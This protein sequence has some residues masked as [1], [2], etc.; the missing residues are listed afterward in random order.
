MASSL[1]T[2]RE[3]VASLS[4]NEAAMTLDYLRRLRSRRAE[5][6]F[7]ELLAGDPAIRMPGAP[8]ER[9][10]EVQPVNG[11][12]IPASEMLVQDRG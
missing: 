3:T 5:T 12:G 2:P 10:P 11:A 8:C 7:A 6:G 1:D 9:L 4:E